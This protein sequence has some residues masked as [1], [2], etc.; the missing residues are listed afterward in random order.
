MAQDSQAGKGAPK[1]LMSRPAR[2][3]FWVA[4][5]MLVAGATAGVAGLLINI[6][7]HKQE[8]RT[9]FVR[10]VE[11]NEISTDPVPWGTNWPS[12]FDTYRRTV[13]VVETQ[14]GG[15]S[16]MPASKLEAAPWLKRLYAGYA[17]SLDYREARGHAYML[18][19]Q[20]VTER[21]TKRPQSGA[22][23]HCHA[24]MIPTYRRLGMQA[25]GLD[26]TPEA[27]AADFNWPAVM[28]GFRL[29]STLD[30]A[31]AH[32]ELL[33]TPDGTP[34]EQTP[35]FPGGSATAPSTP[36]KPPDHPSPAAGEAHPVSCIDCHDPATMRLRV[37][38]PGLVQGLTALAEGE[39]PVDHLPSLGRWRA[40]DRAR[41]Y[42]PNRDATR[43]E[44]R[45]LVCAQCHVEYYCA[46][47]M[48]LTFPWGRGLRAED[49]EAF[50]DALAFPDGSDFYDYAHAETGA[51]LYK[52]Q[53][54]EFELWSQ[55]IH[56]RSG[57][58]CADCHMPY[59][60]QGAMKVSSHWVQSPLLTVNT[61]CQTC[62]AVPE[63]ELRSR[64]RT[65]QGRTEAMLERAAQAMV[66][67]LDAM[68]E[69]K[70]S[71]ASPEQLAR[72]HEVQKKAM[73]RL[74]YISSENSMG[75]HADQEAVRVLGESID[76]SRQAQVMAV[77]LRAP[78]APP[79]SP[80]GDPQIL[81]VTP[82]D[83]APPA[84][85]KIPGREH[86]KTRTP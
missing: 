50:W 11:V 35:M 24:S 19:D 58:S 84:P 75:F 4:L 63:A 47:N 45:S 16:A 28:E 17:F 67:M 72:L 80:P 9:P 51:R 59:D 48:T 52:A 86:L 77:R 29:A 31:S 10:L 20:E 42:D 65:I 57:V 54:P 6:F 79:V 34:G 38:R 21:V 26:P 15:S 43:Q 70:A 5:L 23:L 85:Y 32:A 49:I 71:G 64:V 55:G 22:C 39:G 14:Y 40:G 3:V 13:D 27:L 44:L 8:A 61:S 62:H 7:T 46:S 78:A 81:G 66:D 36:S 73:W 25:M 30:Y 53:H 1:R 82:T 60:R 83:K 74:D 76:F 41:P 2:A 12:Q 56:A 18:F 33:N 37:T 69:A 68:G